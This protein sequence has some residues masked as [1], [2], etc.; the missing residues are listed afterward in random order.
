MSAWESA[1]PNSLQAHAFAPFHLG[2]VF[3]CADVRQNRDADETVSID[4]AI[5]LGEIIVEPLND[6][7]ERRLIADRRVAHVESE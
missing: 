4:C 7:D 3:L 6:G 2:N 1:E 5:F